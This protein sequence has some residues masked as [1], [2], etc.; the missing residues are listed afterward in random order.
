[1]KT[2]SAELKIGEGWMPSQKTEMPKPSKDI[3][4]LDQI[5]ATTPPANLIIP[6]ESCQHAPCGNPPE[7]K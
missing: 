6:P 1:M 7:V 3:A 4:Y 2:H 5:K